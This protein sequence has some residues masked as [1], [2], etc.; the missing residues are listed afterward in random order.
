FLVTLPHDLVYKGGMID[1]NRATG[2]YAELFVVIGLAFAL[3]FA[4]V[5]FAQKA[6]KETIVYLDKKIEKTASQQGST[7]DQSQDTINL[8]AIREK[9]KSGSKEDKLQQGL[10][11]LC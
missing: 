5:F 9:I 8:T 2:V 3:S 1:S 11:E 7:S 10:N 6:K 4:S